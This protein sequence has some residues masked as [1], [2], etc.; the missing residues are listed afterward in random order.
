MYLGM[1]GVNE[2]ASPKPAVL[3]WLFQPTN[4]TNNGWTLLE[5]SYT[6][7]TVLSGTLA[8]DVVG[9]S[10]SAGFAGTTVTVSNRVGGNGTIADV[11]NGVVE[12]FAELPSELQTRGVD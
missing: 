7:G 12:N 8:F 2:A 10:L 11:Y 4:P 9:N 5:Y 1:L 6:T 3:I